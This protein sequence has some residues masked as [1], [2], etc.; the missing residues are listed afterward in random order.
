MPKDASHTIISLEQELNDLRRKNAALEKELAA[1][2]AN[3]ESHVRSQ[4]S[5]IQANAFE[6]D[7]PGHLRFLEKMEQVNKAIRKAPDLD[8]LL[9]DVLDA[10]LDIFGCERAW[11]LY[12]CDPGAS[13]WNVPM[14]R[15]R[16]AYP[17]A[18]AESVD[19]PMTDEIRE[20]FRLF[21]STEEPVRFDPQSGLPLP[22]QTSERFG[23]KSQMV[24][25]V[26]PKNDRPWVFGIHHCEKAMTYSDEDVR[27]FKS[28]ARRLGDALTSMLALRD[29]QDSENMFRAITEN[30]SDATFILD[31]AGNCVYASPSARSL[32]ALP[33]ADLK[34]LSPDA[35]IHPDDL[36]MFYR[37][38]GRAMTLP[39]KTVP[40]SEFRSLPGGR[41]RFFEGL[42]T[43][44]ADLPGVRGVVCNF[45]NIT[46][47]RR[48]ETALRESEERYRLL[49]E[50]I[51]EVFWLS[52]SEMPVQVLY[53][54]PA[55]EKIW[56]RPA[57]EL[58]ADAD[59]WMKAIH[60][61]DREWVERAFIGLLKGDNDFNVEYRLRKPGGEI[62][63]IH[64]RASPIRDS[65][66]ALTGLAGFA[67]DIT[68][69]RTAEQA[70][71]RAK[72]FTEKLIE[73]ANVFFVAL[74]HEGRIVMIN[75]AAERITGY[76]REELSG[77]NWFETLVPKNRYPEVWSLLSG[78]VPKRYENPIL[79]KSGEERFIS[80]Q[81][82]TLD[83]PGG[84]ISTVSF[85]I[86]IT[87]RKR[88]EEALSKSHEELSILY[89]VYRKTTES[90]DPEAI[91]G[92]ALSIMEKRL[93][94]DGLCALLLDKEGRRLSAAAGLDLPPALDEA[95]KSVT[96]GEGSAGLAVSRMTP[97]IN[98]ASTCPQPAV[99]EALTQIG[100]EVILAFP[101]QAGKKAVGAI[102][103]F[104]K[105]PRDFGPED[106][107]LFMA[108]GQ[109]VG[110]AMHNAQ[111]FES[112]TLELFQRKQ[113]EHELLLAKQAA[114]RANQAKSVFLANMSHEIRTPMNSI[115][116]LGHLTLQTKLDPRQRDY[117]AKIQSAAN[118]LLGIINDIL[119]FSKIEAGK[120]DLEH[121]DF[122]LSLVMADVLAMFSV[123]AAERNLEM[124]MDL[125]LEVPRA[126]NGDPL[127]LTQILTNLLNNAIKFTEDGEIAIRVALAQEEPET[128]KVTLRFEVSDTGIGM[129]AD[130]LE[131]L[132]IPFSQGDPSTTRKYGGTGLG[133]VICKRLVAMMGGE[134][135]VTSVPGQG[136]VFAFTA[137]LLRQ[138]NVC[139][140][141]PAVPPDLRGLRVLAVDDSPASLRYLTDALAGF[142]FSVTARNS[143]EQAL[144]EVQRGLSL[145]EFPFNLIVLD[146]EMRGP[147]GPDGMGG[148]GGMDGL[149]AG[150]AIM[151]L[152]KGRP[153]PAMILL[154][155]PSGEEIRRKA[156]EAGFDA[157]VSKP[158]FPSSLFDAIMDAFGVRDSRISSREREQTLKEGWI[159]EIRGKRALLAEDN[160]LNRQM[161]AELLAMAGIEVALAENGREAVEMAF[162]SGDHPYDIA[163]MDVQM[164]VMDGLEATRRI[165]ADKRFADMPILAMT[166]N[167]L[168]GDKEACLEAGM[169]GHIG[170]PIDIR[171]LFR[172]L[173]SW[174]KPDAD[175]GP[176]CPWIPTEAPVDDASGVLSLN[177]PDALKR[178]DGDKHLYANLLKLFM[179]EHA[180]ALDGIRTFL[181]S[182][183]LKQARE[184]A[185]SLKGAA[186]NLGAQT[187]QEAAA[188]ME[189]ALKKEERAT[190]PELMT[191]L[192]K[193]YKE[194]QEAIRD[195]LDNARPDEA[196][197]PS[198][199]EEPSLGA[200]DLEDI[201]SLFTEM[202][203]YLSTNNMQALKLFE[204]IQERLAGMREA[205]RL[206]PLEKSVARLDFRGAIERLDELSAALFSAKDA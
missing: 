27:L 154:I 92:H 41:E 57:S 64:D 73:T 133:L 101:L 33:G 80:W 36:E 10:T 8:I 4:T 90:L 2:G 45:R 125:P 105:A 158:I 39:G 97:V 99:R 178:L 108:I 126:L 91:L 135:S 14:E 113:A 29:L 59:A 56:G 112:V 163:L 3:L 84:R 201:R 176:P 136:S 95:L 199:E 132:F 85:G 195:Y 9:Q 150:R 142:T 134:I 34:G 79:T 7:L 96:V 15:N 86:D 82:G 19:I 32:F 75:E 43:S 44:M 21:L 68:E 188:A 172:A 137:N 187:L 30:S 202:R 192:A 22:P 120:L 48:A 72:E 28:I 204:T 170:K 183:D 65:T 107:R 191:S 17:G 155:P 109:Q 118:S 131:R 123:R 173:H 104:T 147:D 140:R 169:N 102:V 55:F 205:E 200:A 60:E 177:V 153:K 141:P 181:D 20:A 167:V 1:H 111:L 81:N 182:D 166:A 149:D 5:E 66:G 61:N 62:R 146:L 40:L 49:T 110:T 16:P 6:D 168:K 114:E 54:S 106:L 122:N 175:T 203:G 196:P 185:H 52:T 46:N 67:Q 31:P 24:A 13:S 190:L 12:P 25:A 37:V 179:E 83:D 100:A 144:L 194:A 165:R 63:W 78:P 128:G 115:I 152:V 148:M 164:P 58:Y 76:S 38:L 69:R 184:L 197:L 180:V 129:R 42:M 116:G 139:E 87:E 11:M 124:L 98:T 174:L 145:L 93:A 198:A 35:Y 89:D 127:R 206:A 70:A 161:A 121:E 88:F 94:V 119:D 23:I 160:R 156:R 117:L 26:H 130:Q 151:E 47:R 138:T 186:G 143:G 50:N 189:Q 193:T 103:M 157:C 162:A 53:V 159:Q 71:R 51:D 77:E 171:Q 18:F 74:D